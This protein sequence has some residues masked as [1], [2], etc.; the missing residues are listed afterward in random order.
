LLAV[1]SHDTHAV[2]E[3]DAHGQQ[4]LREEAAL[5]IE[6]IVR[7]SRPGP[8]DHQSLLRPVVQTLKIKQLAQRQVDEGRVGR[9]VE[10]RQPLP[11][12]HDGVVDILYRHRGCHFYQTDR[13]RHDTRGYH[14]AR[15][16]EMRVNKPPSQIFITTL[17]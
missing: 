1:P 12:G 17:G 15:W 16:E 6:L 9:A 3:T 14:K 13:L 8:R 2:A 11:L 4:G 7:P 10:D 5:V